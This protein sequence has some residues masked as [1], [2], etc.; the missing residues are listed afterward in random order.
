MQPVFSLDVSDLAKDLSTISELS[1]AQITEN[2]F[3]D[4]GSQIVAKAQSN[5]PFKTGALKNSIEYEASANKLVI[6]VG[7][8][9]GTFQEFGTGVRGEFS[10][11]TY[12]IRPKRAK[13]L[14]FVVGGKVVYTKHVRH[15]GIRAHPY[16]RPAAIEVLGPLL[17]KLADRGQAM[18]VKGPN[19]TL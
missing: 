8:P 6:D 17:D 11:T 12:D 4:L 16:L 19:S 7:V 10:G 13:F 9:Y 18:I 1:P 3:N 14:R 2:I 5:A 15:P